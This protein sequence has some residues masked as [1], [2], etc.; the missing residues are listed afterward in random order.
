MSKIAPIW[1]HFFFSFICIG[2]QGVELHFISTYFNYITRTLTMPML[3]LWIHME[4]CHKKLKWQG[5]LDTTLCDK[6]CQWHATCRW[7]LP[8]IPVPFTNKTDRHDMTEDEFE[9]TKGAISNIVESGVKHHNR[10]Q[11]LT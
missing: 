2:N 9:D 7:F 4:V 1:G 11:N 6:V 3:Q 5:V 10:N 8:G